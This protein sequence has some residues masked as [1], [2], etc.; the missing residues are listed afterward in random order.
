MPHHIKYSIL[1][2]NL[3]SYIKIKETNNKINGRIQID[4]TASPNWVTPEGNLGA[5][6]EQ[7]TV[8]IT[9]QAT[10]GDSG[11][12]T[13][14][15]GLLPPIG[16]ENSYLPLGLTINN[17]TGV[18]SGTVM[19]TMTDPVNIQNF[20]A[21]ETPLWNDTSY[22]LGKFNELEDVNFTD[23]SATPRKGSTISYY[24]KNGSLPLGLTLNRSTCAIEGNTGQ[25]I[26]DYTIPPSPE[27]KPRWQT[28]T[29][30]IGS[31]GEFE[32]VSI[33]LSAT[34]MRG[35]EISYFVLSGAL[36]IGLTLN[37]ITGEIS[38]N[39][40]ENMNPNDIVVFGTDMFSPIITTNTDLGS[41]SI[42]ST[43]SIT[44]SA[45]PQSER[46]IVAYTV[47]T[48]DVDSD[49]LP[50]GLTLDRTTGV[51]SG[52]I[53][54]INPLGTYPIT[55]RVY[56]NTGRWTTKSFTISITE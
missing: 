39:T 26:T 48:R 34:P 13:I 24:I 50:I 23:A 1:N 20:N 12:T 2:S 29:G 45:T 10:V 8:N 6:L 28:L 3:P 44:I 49:G 55:I 36:P 37:R 53:S 15:Y 16:I 38:G 35:V 9:L 47:H 54:A 14:R 40:N 41:H 42:S 43:P 30:K 52:T 46:S 7:D 19:E 56:D 22:F 21:D 18:V 33:T 11:G 25:V 31:F 51:I 17:D 27:P 4:S 32:D 5:F